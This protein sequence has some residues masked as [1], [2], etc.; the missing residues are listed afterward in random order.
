LKIVF[1]DCEYTGEHSITTL[2]SLGLVTL[3]GNELY[4]TLNDY[5]DSQISH[6]VN[7]N[8]ISKI[9]K[10]KSLNSYKACIEVD[11]FLKKYSNGENVII[12]S[13]GK[14]TDIILIFQL[15]H[16]LHTHRKYF[17][18]SE[19]LPDYINHRMHIDLDTMF[20]MAGINPKI[21]REEYCKSSDANKHNAL[22][23]AKIV[24]KCYL[25]LLNENQSIF[26]NL[27][28]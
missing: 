28:N 22:Y 4:L 10:R 19:C 16:S 14:A 2:V 5:E 13:A 25:K 20:I 9:D 12:V 1:A 7:E 26:K 24:R 17:H 3:D 11:N 21:N 6:W 15:Y 27:K 8:V 18:F 23:D